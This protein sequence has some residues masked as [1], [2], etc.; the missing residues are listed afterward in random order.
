MSSI[1]ASSSS[2][3]AALSSSILDSLQ[4]EDVMTQ[5]AS[6]IKKKSSPKLTQEIV[7]KIKAQLPDITSKKI[8]QR[9][10]AR[11]HGLTVK[12]TKRVIEKLNNGE[13][14][15]EKKFHHKV[16]EKIVKLVKERRELIESEKMSYNKAG[17]ECGITADTVK[18]IVKLLQEG[19][20]PTQ[21]K[22]TQKVT[23]KIWKKVVELH[24]E[25][26]LSHT[27]IA[28]KVKIAKT[29]V[30]DIIRKHT[31]G[32][33][34]SKRR[35]AQKITELM[36]EQVKN[37][38]PKIEAKKLSQKA[39]ALQCNITEATFSKIFRKLTKGENPL[40]RRVA[41]QVTDKDVENVKKFLPLIKNGE[42]TQ[43]AAAEKCSISET[44][45]SHIKGTI[46]KGQN[47]T[48]KK[49]ATTITEAMLKKMKAMLPAFD[50]G[51]L[52]AKDAAETL[53]I[54]LQSFH[55]HIKKVRPKPSVESD[56]ELEKSSSSSSEK[57]AIKK[58]SKER[59]PD[60]TETESESESSE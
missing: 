12:V 22:V 55:E 11:E 60:E 23:E 28:E 27:V 39:A 8:S 30:S 26:K 47:P 17:K 43:R 58:K 20:D 15:L 10:V 34:F 40:E 50:D 42:I 29:Q 6:S 14:P 59:L 5:P 32:E 18:K 25:G 52:L 33:S 3:S 46:E 9:S 56:S 31:D 48:Q 4:Q 45:F 13:D 36:I 2:V 16:T 24:Q 7:D 44:S 21:R 37:L 51:T 49:S 19:K 38:R 57:A 1:S 54:S 41:R 35:P 53:K